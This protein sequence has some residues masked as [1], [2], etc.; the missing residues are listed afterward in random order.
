MKFESY[1]SDRQKWVNSLAKE[2]LRLEICLDLTVV[3][4]AGDEERRSFQCHKIILLS[5][6]KQFCPIECLVDVE[7]VILPETDPQ[8][9]EEY[10]KIEYGFI[11]GD[12]PEASFAPALP[13]VNDPLKLKVEE[14][15]CDEEDIEN[16]YE[17]E[18]D[19]KEE[20]VGSLDDE[21][22]T[23]ED[24]MK[25][26]C[27][28]KGK[29]K[30]KKRKNEKKTCHICGKLVSK[31]KFHLHMKAFHGEVICACSVK[32]SHEFEY[33]DHKYSFGKE[34]RKIHQILS[35]S[36][37]RYSVIARDNKEES[38]EMQRSYSP[39]TRCHEAFTNGFLLRRHMLD[40]HWDELKLKD[41]LFI[42]EYKYKVKSIFCDYAGCERYRR[43]I[44]FNIISLILCLSATLQ[45]KMKN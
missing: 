43:Y 11:N 22:D 44:I 42:N 6:L 10:L 1:E 35:D 31:A 34:E 28:D 9:F 29:A 17:D 30:T 21:F 41:M 4:G 25:S 5:F 40:N 18:Y 32:F 7:E 3:C 19:Y 39:C 24:D 15:E 2:W 20:D 26:I 45:D 13:D 33:Y 38:E 14:D 23:K 16:L 12:L 37:S 8:V 36:T 27:K